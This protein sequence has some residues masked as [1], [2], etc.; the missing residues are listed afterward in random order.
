MNEAIEGIS[1]V[2]LRDL[3]KALKNTNINVL[4]NRIVHKQAYRP[5]EEEA[6]SA[7]MEARS[8]LFRLTFHLKLHDD[9]NWYL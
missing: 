9:I 6:V 8:I 5:T 2:D 4:R 1:S 3:L 7:L